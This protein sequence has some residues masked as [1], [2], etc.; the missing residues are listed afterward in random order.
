MPDPSPSAPASWPNTAANR[1][2]LA[3]LVRRL[4]HALLA[5]SS[6]TQVL[7]QWCATWHAA[8][9]ARIAVRI[10]PAAPALP[11][12]AMRAR[13]DVG[14]DDRIGHRRVCLHWEGR[15]L[16]EADNWYVPAR[17]SA[18]MNATLAASSEPFGRVI[19]PLRPYRTNLRALVLWQADTDLGDGT[20]TIPSA[21]LRH[22]A[23]IRSVRGEP[24][25][26]VHE[27]YQRGVLPPP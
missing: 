13:L 7:E 3:A 15:I 14:G 6:A 22:E 17:L 4:H 9:A 8:A 16:S 2:H 25:A 19:A 11:D 26:E 5:A 20:I 23:V 1:A 27:V 18:G 12:D 24:L 10:V 21:V